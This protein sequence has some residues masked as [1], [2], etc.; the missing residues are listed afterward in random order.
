VH[1]TKPGHDYS[2]REAEMPTIA[3]DC[4]ARVCLWNFEA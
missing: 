3:F 2:M 1:S 4:I